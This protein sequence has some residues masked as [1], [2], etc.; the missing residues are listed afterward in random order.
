MIVH[1]TGTVLAVVGISDGIAIF[2]FSDSYRT[3]KQQSEYRCSKAIEF[4]ISDLQNWTS[5]SP[6]ANR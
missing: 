3:K 5:D 4:Q 6:I 1:C 2:R